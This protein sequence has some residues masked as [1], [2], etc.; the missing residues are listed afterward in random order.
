MKAKVWSKRRTMR[1][2]KSEF[3]KYPGLYKV[4]G[5]SACSSSSSTI[6]MSD[7]SDIQNWSDDR[8]VDNDDNPDALFEAKNAEKRRCRLVRAEEAEKHRK[9]AEAEEHRKVAEVHH[10]AEEEAKRKAAEEAA[11]KRV[12]VDRKS[13]V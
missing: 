1:S 11:K 3:E 5:F 12:S 9:V 13:V 2:Q 7:F 10:K 8:L 4:R 6:I